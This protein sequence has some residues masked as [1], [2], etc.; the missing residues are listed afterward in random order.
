MKNFKNL[1]INSSKTTEQFCFIIDGSRYYRFN[2]KYA[3]YEQAVVSEKKE[4]ASR[5]GNSCES[6]Q[7]Y[8][9]F[10]GNCPI[11]GHSHEN[12]PVIKPKR[13]LECIC[14]SCCTIFEP[15]K[16]QS[17]VSVLD[18]HSNREEYAEYEELVLEEETEQIVDFVLDDNLTE[19]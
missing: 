4:Y 15:T 6:K 13:V 11:C 10:T 14:E 17:I 9:I 2:G 12:V 1:F 16:I 5:T 3:L 18:I 19:E 8:G 7:V